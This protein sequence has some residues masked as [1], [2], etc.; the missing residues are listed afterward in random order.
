MPTL[1]SVAQHTV[2]ALRYAEAVRPAAAEVKPPPTSSE[3]S[4]RSADVTSGGLSLLI[5]DSLAVLVRAQAEATVENRQIA[6]NAAAHAYA[7]ALGS[8]TT[9]GSIGLY[10]LSV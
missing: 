9:L 8:G 10:G 6:L 1:D 2:V 3:A 5:S 7:I 4:I